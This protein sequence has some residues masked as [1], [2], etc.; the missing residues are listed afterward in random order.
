MAEEVPDVSTVIVGPIL[1]S[2]DQDALIVP[3]YPSTTW[4]LKMAEEV[5]DVSTV[6]VG[7][8]L[9]SQDQDALIVPRYPS[10]TWVLKMA[11][12]DPNSPQNII[13]S[14]KVS[15]GKIETLDNTDKLGVSTV[16]VEPILGSQD[17]DALIVPR[18]P[19]KNKIKIK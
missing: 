16:L 7:P 13:E 9:G 11:E 14:P 18:Y 3:R 12:E 19:Y 4:V 8:I 6:L 15:L 5:P 1:G 10:K 2:Q 17:Q